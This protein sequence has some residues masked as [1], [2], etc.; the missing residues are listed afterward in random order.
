MN[1]YEYETKQ[2]IISSKSKL[3]LLTGQHLP[4]NQTV[5]R[6]YNYQTKQTSYFY[7]TNEQLT[8]HCAQPA[9]IKKNYRLGTRSLNPLN[10]LKTAFKPQ[11]KPVYLLKKPPR[12]TSPFIQ[13]TEHF[14]DFQEFLITN[15]LLFCQKAEFIQAPLEQSPVSKLKKGCDQNPTN[16]FKTKPL[17][18]FK[19]AKETVPLVL[20]FLNNL[21]HYVDYYDM[22]ESKD[23]Y[24]PRFTDLT[25]SRNAYLNQ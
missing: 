4:K 6:C 16:H 15:L 7:K 2:A 17:L 9:F 21:N 11:P 10:L 5:F 14:K 18:H 13:S 8:G 25:E 24:D 1:L 20:A 19:F 23:F 22:T 3:D 12:Q